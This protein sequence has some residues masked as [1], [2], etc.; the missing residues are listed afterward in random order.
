M[1]WQKLLGQAEEELDSPTANHLY[2]LAVASAQNQCGLNHANLAK[3]L[4]AYAGFLERQQNF[5]DARKRYKMA[6]AI[7]KKFGQERLLTFAQVKVT[8]ME[9]M[10]HDSFANPY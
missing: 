7:F 8:R 2:T 5:G 10:T 4:M 9:V 3:C 6:A 1:D